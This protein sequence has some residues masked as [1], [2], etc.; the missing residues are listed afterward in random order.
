MEPVYAI[1]KCGG[2]KVLFH[3]FLTSVA[4]GGKRS[5][6]HT[7]C[8]TPSEPVPLYPQNMM[9]DNPKASLDTLE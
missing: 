2:R 9:F 3:S 4:D 6:S 1:N 7:T 5:A 8:C